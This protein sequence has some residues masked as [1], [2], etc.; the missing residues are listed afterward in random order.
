VNFLLEIGSEEI[1]HW[2]IP[3]AVEQLRRM[4]L[5]G[6]APQVDAT[7]RRLVVRASGLP[8]RTSDEEQIV[9]GPPVSAGDKA[10]SGFAKKQGVEL[11]AV[12]KSGDYYELHKHVPGRAVSDLLAG[13]LPGAILSLQWPKTMYWTGKAGPRFI[14]P[15]RWIVAM[16]GNQVIPFEIAGV[17][18]GSVTRGHRRLGSA[19]IPV[20]VDSY[21]SELRKN[22]VILSSDE[23]REKIEREAGVL[24]AKLDV[25]LLETLTYIT[26][27]P[28]AIK[29]NF[30]PAYLEL[31]SEVL[32][33]VMRHHQKY[34][35]VE[36]EP[37]K[38]APHFVA[39]M[40]TS[41]DP[42]GLVKRGNERVL[43]AR[44]NDARFFWTTDLNRALV[45][46]VPDLDRVTFHA[47]LGSYFFKTERMKALVEELGGNANAQ[48]AA[49]LCKAD[50]TTEMVKEFTD[51]QGIMGG[52]YARAQGEP[53]AVWRAIYEHY[54]PLS[55]EDSIPAT[56]EGQIVALADK[57]DTLQQCFRIGLVPTGSKDPL[58]LR[59]AA[60][61]VV[62]ILAEARLDYELGDL[63]EGELRDFLL[64]RI[65]YYFREI[66]GFKY[67]EV[68]AVLASGAGTVADV[69]ARLI[70][71]AAVRPTE[72]FEPLAA[73]FK[74]I[75]NILKQANFEGGDGSPD[76]SLLEA[77]PEADLHREF[78]RV[79]V[80]AKDA[81]YQKA[82]EDIAS[83]RPQVDTFF[84]KVLVNAK[85]QKVRANR[86][87]LLHN[88]LTE[89]S[90]IA[91]FSEIVTSPNTAH[92]AENAVR[93]G[94][95]KS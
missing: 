26:E 60:Q 71:L 54:K 77:G 8:E 20:T 31:P 94:E 6:A 33:T 43:K 93:S 15:I 5:F 56:P 86:L 61:G 48:S 51:L 36:A 78:E 80:A 38:L 84:D 74:R 57:L 79:R 17:K 90:T 22:F 63:A 62:K 44:F 69:E 53:E 85:D 28:A 9:K 68:S 67:D 73:S 35:S 42:E 46:R 37:G 95:Q 75:Q 7:P 72:N 24:G 88:L 83:L 3:G 14:R 64:D 30:D 29:G 70:A 12:Q 81:G 45:D 11:S 89:F 23:R 34:F 59:R 66:R 65:K 41:G 1:P 10:A 52:L 91:D 76:P 25:E 39:V 82:L 4:D 40:N 87:T 49:Y 19:S 58:A 55:M 50:L 2:M 27:Y 32:T 47:K 92:N 13:S 16:L 18:S 21:E